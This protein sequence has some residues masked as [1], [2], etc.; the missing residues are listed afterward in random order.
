MRKHHKLFIGLPGIFRWSLGETFEIG[1]EW[2][3]E[4]GYVVR[5]HYSKGTMTLCNGGRWHHHW[6]HL[7]W[8]IRGWIHDLRCGLKRVANLWRNG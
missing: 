2:Y 1:G 8:R 3:P 5:I 6:H 4:K 7:E